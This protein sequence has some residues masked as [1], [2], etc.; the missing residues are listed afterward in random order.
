MGSRRTSTAVKASSV[1]TAN[2]NDITDT[3]TQTPVVR[4]LMEWRGDESRSVTWLPYLT[5]PIKRV[6]VKF[7]V[8]DH[9]CAFHVIGTP[10]IVVAV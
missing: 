10:G 9:H 5:D 6:N 4:T 8:V 3:T 1:G 7:L 2:G